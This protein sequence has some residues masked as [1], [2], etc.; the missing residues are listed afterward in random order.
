M[1]VPLLTQ[2][3][4]PLLAGRRAEC[5]EIISRAADDGWEAKSLINDV[6]WPSMSQVDRLYR[7]DRITCV[8][9]HMATRI[10][11]TVAD[12]LQAR[13]PRAV[14][15]GKRVIICCAGGF[16]EEL[17]A[18]MVADLFQSDGWE[19]FFLG[20]GIPD[21]E[22]LMLIGQKRPDALVI[23]GV[24]PAETPLTR[25]VIELIREVDSCPTMNIVVAG[26]VFNRADGLWQEVGA[27]AFAPDADEVVHA[28]NA[29][30]PRIPGPPRR[31]TV[32]KRQ[33]RRRGTEKPETKSISKA[34]LSLDAVPE[35]MLEDKSASEAKA[36]TTKAKRVTV[37]HADA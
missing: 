29:L 4:Q 31:G 13:L 28:V 22:L 20:G 7:D 11:R 34:Q 24:E 16:R 27:D 12:Q 9:E 15:N 2:Y 35:T 1:S 14:A 17:G 6:L 37:S 25:R 18:Q 5:F 26:G 8:I 33:R 21:D 36:S 32:K 10:N 23:F 30:A 19:V 3:L